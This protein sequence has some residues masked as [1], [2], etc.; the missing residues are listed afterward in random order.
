MTA[1]LSFLDTFAIWIYLLGVVGI[2]FGIK[3]L[4]DARRAGRT[5]LF[6]LEQEQASDRAFRAVLVMGSFTLLIAA[7]AGVNAFVSPNVPTQA[8]DILTPTVPPYTP[9]LIFPTATRIPTQTSL[10]PTAAPTVKPT[11]PVTSTLAAVITAAPQPTAPVE[12]PTAV[13]PPTSA[14]IYLAPALNV[15]PNGDSI[16]SN[17]VRFSWGVDQFGN[18]A[19]PAVLPPDQFYRLAISFTDKDK[20]AAARI[21]L[22]THENSVDQRTGVNVSDYRTQAVDSQFTWNVTIVRAAS[23]AA[24]EAGEFSPLSPPSATFS[25]ILP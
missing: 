19:V 11:A 4:F 20:Y 16:G 7:V 22:C 13:P 1:F 15:P 23:Q 25:F 18:L 3:M 21:V 9:P 17:K 8:P 2:L 14:L 10:P 12:P 24:C 5:T 6:T